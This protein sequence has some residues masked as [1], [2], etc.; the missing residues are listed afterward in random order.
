MN[1]IKVF[2][3]PIQIDVFADWLGYPHLNNYEWVK[4]DYIY[5]T[6]DQSIKI[7][8]LPVFF[9][10]YD[11]FKNNL[12]NPSIFDL[13][14]FSDIE[15]NNINKIIK[16]ID[17][18]KIKNYLLAM[19][20]IDNS[21]FNKLHSNIIYRP[22]WAFNIV[23]RNKFEDTSNLTKKLDFDVLL[24]AKKSHRDFVMAKMQT[25][26]LIDNSI[27]NYR[28]I[29][30]GN[31]INPKLMLHTKNILNGQKLNYPYISP[32]LNNDWEVK[33][34]L[35]NDVSDQAPWKIYE[36]TKYSIICETLCDD[37][38]FLTEKTGKALFCKRLFV[39]FST[40][41]FLKNM[42]LLGFKTFDSILDESYDSEPDIVKRFELAFTQV[43]WLVNQ[44][45][46]EI[47]AKVGPILDHNHNRLIEYK[48]EIKTQM[49][50][51][52]Y[53]KIKEIK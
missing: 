8:C 42:K 43:Q 33:K 46:T 48:E 37:V 3:P 23:N 41:G 20:A 17:D 34:N 35:T 31:I 53:N 24:G 6:F 10:K 45:C 40:C 39:I 14:L 26:G 13:V 22:W 38:F 18:L 51:M 7:A 16:W 11:Y 21:N 49:L 12:F 52:V 47:I 5:E 1:N 30:P 19:G 2:N 9:Q 32:N 29:F 28:D 50:G 4:T 36:Q 27:I 15:Y 44:D 25:S